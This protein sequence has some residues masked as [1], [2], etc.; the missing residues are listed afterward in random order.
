MRAQ[1]P[2]RLQ[3]SFNTQSEGCQGV[4]E[5]GQAAGQGRAGRWD[6]GRLG[7]R[8]EKTTVLQPAPATLP[9]GKIHTHRS[10]WHWLHTVSCSCH[11][12]RHRQ[13]SAFGTCLLG[14]GWGGCFVWVVCFVE[15]FSKNTCGKSAAT[16]A[17]ITNRAV[18]GAEKVSGAC[19]R[20]RRGAGRFNFKRGREGRGR[21]GTVTKEGHCLQD[22]HPPNGPLTV[23]TS[24]WSVQRGQLPE[25]SSRTEPG[26]PRHH[27]WGRG[28]PTQ[29]HLASA[30]CRQQ[31]AQPAHDDQPHVHQLQVYS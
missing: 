18:L 4:S 10:R 21:A 29:V 5:A 27:R 2:L 31:S 1:P 20:W 13:C 8:G 6:R 11:E 30:G 17:C 24:C 12:T 23:W 26:S 9:L 15:P 16:H 28:L 14:S 25:P 19:L 7:A 22:V 3:S